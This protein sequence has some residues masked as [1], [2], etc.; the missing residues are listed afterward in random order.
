VNIED[1]TEDDDSDGEVPE[2][3]CGWLFD[4]AT[5]RLLAK[6]PALSEDF[7]RDQIVLT[8]EPERKAFITQLVCEYQAMIDAE[9][10]V[11]E[12]E[13]EAKVGEV[14]C[15]RLGCEAQPSPYCPGD[16]VRYFEVI[17]VA[18]LDVLVEV[19]PRFH[20]RAQ[21]GR[22]V[23]GPIRG[24]RA[25]RLLRARVA[26]GGE[27]AVYGAKRRFTAMLLK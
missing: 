23:D 5:E 25:S 3:V 1:E 21:D 6:W 9:P 12:V 16:D 24:V 17:D 19:L 7:F 13:P 4:V 14:Y 8:P 10:A 11:P 20:Y 27:L 15:H 22:W 2:R 26:G 18:D